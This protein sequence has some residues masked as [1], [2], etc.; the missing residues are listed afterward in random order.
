MMLSLQVALRDVLARL[1]KTDSL[2]S[3]HSKQYCIKLGNWLDVYKER[4][5]SNIW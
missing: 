5:E 1:I 3:E 2:I 4:G